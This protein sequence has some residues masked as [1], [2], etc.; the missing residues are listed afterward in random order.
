M[1]AA[2]GGDGARAPLLTHSPGSSPLPSPRAPCKKEGFVPAEGSSTSPD[3]ECNMEGR[4]SAEW[5]RQGSPWD[6]LGRLGW[7]S[8][9]KTGAGGRAI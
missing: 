1:G 2:G 9:L 6:K 8:A 7:E 3:N 5:S 4:S